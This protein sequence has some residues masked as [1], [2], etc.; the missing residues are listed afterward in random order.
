MADPTKRT[1]TLDGR[2][3]RPDGSIGYRRALVRLGDGS[4]HGIPIPADL[5]ED[6]ARA[7]LAE[8]QAE[9]NARGE[10]LAAKVARARKRG[11]A[12]ARAG[13][14]LETCDAW[15]ERYNAHQREIGQT[16]AG[17]KR[18]RWRKWIKPR[19][20]DRTMVS[21]TRD[22]VEDIR[23][24]LDRAIDEW[25]KTGGA[26]AGKKGT[27]ISGKTAMNI[28]SALTSS[29][30]AA[31]SSKRR[32]L[33]ILEGKP[34]PCL[35]VEPPGDK[36]SRKARRKTFIYPRE[37]I[38]VLACE[39]VP[40]DWRE[41]YAVALYTYLRPGELRVLTVG[42]VSLEAGHISVTKAWDYE[43]NAT[44]PPKT[45]NGIRNVPIEP[46]LAPLLEHMISGKEPGAL[47]APCLSAFGE[48]HLAEQFRRHLKI[49]GVTRA[50]LH[51]STRTHVQ[52]N[53]RSCRDSGITWLAM[54]GVGVD[55][56]VRRAGHDEVSTSMTYVKQAEDL[57]GALGTPFPPLPRELVGD[58]AP[59]PDEAREDDAAR[60]TATAEDD[61][62]E[63]LED[64]SGEPAEL[65]AS[66]PAPPSPVDYF[67]PSRRESK[68]METLC[69]RRESNPEDDAQPRE[70]ARARAI[71]DT[72]QA[73]V[74]ARPSVSAPNV[75]HS[76]DYSATAALR[77]RNA[78]L[79][80]ALERTA[81]SMRLVLPHVTGDVRDELAERRDELEAL[82]GPAA[83][84]VPIG[85]ARKR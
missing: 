13:A 46:A 80:R 79:E 10:L 32:E 43:E 5:D 84:V 20:G 65:V 1:G 85:A 28:W 18:D 77:A 68:S 11:V 75:D 63:L 41:L 83:A 14:E 4:R 15:F 16:D 69:R 53:F 48:D 42:D 25:K 30:K 40:R 35:G 56:I 36:E 58:A 27:A 6:G 39:R 21:I 47:V 38:A 37:A 19:I 82:G 66:S 61:A 73:H 45:R 34:N 23:D 78:L 67:R 60:V 54:A 74:S 44:K 17:K 24:E 29:F 57:G 72:E 2:F 71:E 55:K 31:T 62:P 52:A 12:V 26:N 50:E 59:P 51:A 81:R 76:E 8:L 3:T 70:I 7:L 49:A 22:D 9:E 64:A 33:R